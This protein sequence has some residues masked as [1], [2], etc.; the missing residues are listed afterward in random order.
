MEIA[1]NVFNFG[2]VGSSA[3]KLNESILYEIFRRRAVLVGEPQ[4]PGKQLRVTLGED[5]F[6]RFRARGYPFWFKHLWI[7]VPR[8]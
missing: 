8:R 3:R 1:I 5:L 2:Q 6:S 4:R 7:N